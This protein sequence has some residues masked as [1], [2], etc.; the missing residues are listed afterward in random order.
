MSV[1][2]KTAYHVSAGLG[3]GFIQQ[4]TLLRETDAYYVFADRYNMTEDRR[5]KK[6]GGI[7]FTF[8][9]AKAE[10]IARLNRELAKVV[11]EHAEADAALVKAI[12][13]TGPTHVDDPVALPPG[14]LRL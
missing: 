6:R 5:L 4:R 13:L 10:L 3:H 8:D 1:Y 7:Y 11:R 14:P 12:N 2:P 9:E